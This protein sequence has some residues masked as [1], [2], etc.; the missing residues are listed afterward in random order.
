MSSNTVNPE[1]RSLPQRE[2]IGNGM[3]IVNGGLK[4]GPFRS[5]AT[6]AA[7]SML[8]FKSVI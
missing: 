1:S 7:S 6:H 5:T 4:F 2:V 8:S 3:V